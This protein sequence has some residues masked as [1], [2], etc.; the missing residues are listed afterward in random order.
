MLGCILLRFCKCT[1]FG[2][3]H[4]TTISDFLLVLGLEFESWLARLNKIIVACSYSTSEA[5]GGSWN[6]SELTISPLEF[7]LTERKPSIQKLQ[8]NNAFSSLQLRCK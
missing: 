7:R 1:K 2:M 3:C 5:W 8:S 6:I 4:G